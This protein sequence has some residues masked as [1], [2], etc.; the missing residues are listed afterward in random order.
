MAGAEPVLNCVAKK[1]VRLRKPLCMEL[2]LYVT[3]F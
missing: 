3:R 2:A 1:L